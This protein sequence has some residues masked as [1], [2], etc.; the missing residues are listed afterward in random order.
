MRARLQDRAKSLCR[1]APSR[2]S[3]RRSR[4]G[5]NAIIEFSKIVAGV[6]DF[7]RGAE[8]WLAI[9]D[10]Q[11]VGLANVLKVEFDNFVGGIDLIVAKVAP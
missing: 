1:N 2:A 8:R 5:L 9:I 10:E 3:N 4:K 11:Q 6:E 7:H